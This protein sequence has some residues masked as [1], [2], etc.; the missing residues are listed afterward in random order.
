MAAA[1]PVLKSY[2]IVDADHRPDLRGEFAGAKVQIIGGRHVVKLPDET[3]R[4]Y[5]DSG[6]IVPLVKEESKDEVKDDHEK[7]VSL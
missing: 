1:G 5:L 6:S 2:V 4:F 3:A 7:K